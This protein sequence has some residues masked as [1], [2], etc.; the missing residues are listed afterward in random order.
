MVFFF[1]FDATFKLFKEFKMSKTLRLVMKI[2]I[3]SNTGSMFDRFQSF[4]TLTHSGMNT[5]K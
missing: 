5:L 1:N 3:T 4:V 2:I